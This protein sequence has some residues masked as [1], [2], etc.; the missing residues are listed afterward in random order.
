M[1][2]PIGKAS[3]SEEQIQQN[4]LE[5]VRTLNKLKPSTSKGKYIRNGVVSLSMSPGVRLDCQELMDAK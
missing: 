4:L 5:L 3:F 1:H 2:A